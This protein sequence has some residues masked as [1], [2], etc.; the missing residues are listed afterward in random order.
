MRINVIPVDYLANQHLIAEAR[1]IKMLPKA[2]KRTLNSKNGLNWSKIP[3]KYT[4]NTGHGYFFYDKLDFIIT[5]F[6]QL[7]YE[8]ARRGFDF[9][10]D[11][12]E[13]DGFEQSHYNSYEPTITDM[14]VNV[15][16]ILERIK[17]KPDWYRYGS[18]K[19]CYEDWELFYN[20]MI[21]KMRMGCI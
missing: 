4:L 13:I 7:L 10:S 12:I 3:K 15:E 1:E 19:M 6:D 20:G 8:C 17:A 5:R 11:E 18:V 16:R 21:E 2:L 14:E 9:K